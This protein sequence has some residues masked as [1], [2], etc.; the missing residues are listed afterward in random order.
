[1]G[2]ICLECDNVSNQSAFYQFSGLSMGFC[3]PLVVAYHQ[4]NAL[5]PLRPTISSHSLQI[6]RHRLL[7]EYVFSRLQSRNR[8][9]RMDVICHADTYRVDFLSARSSS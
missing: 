5:F 6:H 1:M 9:F 7:T 4:K 3:K 2:K 8:N